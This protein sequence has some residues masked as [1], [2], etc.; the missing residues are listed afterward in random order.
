MCC[1]SLIIFLSCWAI[2]ADAVNR[3]AGGHFFFVN[4]R[5]GWRAD[6][7]RIGRTQD[8]GKTWE[9]TDI[10]AKGYAQLFFADESHGWATA[11]KGFDGQLYVTADGGNTWELQNVFPSEHLFGLYFANPNVGWL[12]TANDLFPSVV[13]ILRTLDGGRTWQHKM[14]FRDGATVFFLD[15]QRAWA[16]LSQLNLMVTHDGGDTWRLIPKAGM[17]GMWFVSPSD[18][19]GILPEANAVDKA[20]ADRLYHTTDGGKTWQLL[21]VIAPNQDLGGPYFIDERT[22][23]VMMNT[24]L[25]PGGS[26]LPTQLLH[27]ADGGQTWHVQF[28][29]KGVWLLGVQFITPHRGWLAGIRESR[30]VLSEPPQWV[31]WGTEDGG[32]SW[33][34]IFPGGEL[35]V[36]PRGK[37]ATLWGKLKQ[38]Q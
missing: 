8:S 35:Q 6:Y 36:H 34:E 28:E 30:W 37:L 10:E 32:A 26:L 29:M 15:E 38:Q 4:E 21:P 27:T 1:C 11:F 33:K 9:W 12:A 7:G 2:S 3:S 13:G 31:L 18:G 16:T 14:V 24:P 19:W 22:G 17:Y 5:L 25:H 20:N 23:W